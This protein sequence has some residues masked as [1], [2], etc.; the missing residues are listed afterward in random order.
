M[1]ARLLVDQRAGGMISGHHLVVQ[2]EVGVPSRKR[3]V[4]VRCAAI[5][6]SRRNAAQVSGDLFLE[7]CG[8]KNRNTMPLI[9]KTNG[10][11]VVT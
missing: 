3:A 4:L 9:L 2:R 11:C 8:K 7:R 5:V 6:D 10:D 1:P